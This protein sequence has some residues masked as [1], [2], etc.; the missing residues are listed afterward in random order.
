MKENPYSLDDLLADITHCHD[1]VDMAVDL[2]V[3]V[4]RDPLSTED[5]LKLKRVE[6]LLWATR[7]IADRASRLSHENYAG[8]LRGAAIGG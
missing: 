7:D 6:S 5:T 8:L 3:S 2:A 1:L 4:D